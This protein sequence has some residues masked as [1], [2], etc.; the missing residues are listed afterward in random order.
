MIWFDKDIHRDDLKRFSD[1]ACDAFADLQRIANECHPLLAHRDF[2][3]KH[4]AWAS[5][6]LLCAEIRGLRARMAEILSEQEP[7]R[8]ECGMCGGSGVAELVNADGPYRETCDQCGGTGTNLAKHCDREIVKLHDLPK[9]HAATLSNWIEDVTGD[10]E[11]ADEIKPEIPTFFEGAVLDLMR[12]FH[13]GTW[14]T[15]YR[16]EFLREVKRAA[17]G[18][19]FQQ[20]ALEGQKELKKRKNSVAKLSVM[21]VSGAEHDV[22]VGGIENPEEDITEG[23]P[24][25]GSKNMRGARSGITGEEAFECKD[26]GDKW[27]M[28]PNR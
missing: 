11:P 18:A 8:G 1:I 19:Y 27:G 20:C 17:Q 7:T 16:Q 5:V 2:K 14:T 15:E 25:C 26:C 6:N 21:G 9:K 13:A 22:Q 10:Y 3:G 4:E 12:E 24:G 23:C 28:K